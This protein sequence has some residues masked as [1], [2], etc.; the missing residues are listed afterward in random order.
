M[1]YRMSAHW[2]LT[3]YKELAIHFHSESCFVF[4]TQ[5]LLLEKHVNRE[6]E[7]GGKFCSE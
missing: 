7:N 3:F 1:R 4:L 2:I 5:Q 6:F